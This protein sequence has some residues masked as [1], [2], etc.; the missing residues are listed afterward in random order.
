MFGDKANSSV[1]TRTI[2]NQHAYSV[3]NVC[4]SRDSACDAPNTYGALPSATKTNWTVPWLNNF[5]QNVQDEGLSSAPDAVLFIEVL[6]TEPATMKV[7]VQNIGMN[8]LPASVD[9]GV[10]HV[11]AGGVEY[12]AWRGPDVARSSARP[13]REPRLHGSRSLRSART[14]PS[15]HHHRRGEPDVQRVSRRQ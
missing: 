12:A 5:R 3:T 15:A 11:A 4:D 1:G 13:K 10:F 2:W 8:V 7:T 6:C 14:L 9:V